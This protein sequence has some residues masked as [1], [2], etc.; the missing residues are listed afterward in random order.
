MI[1]V[2]KK[3]PE[4]ITYG[5]AEISQVWTDGEMVW[6][7]SVTFYKWANYWDS[8]AGWPKSRAEWVQHCV[9]AKW[10][11]KEMEYFA[12]T[13][14]VDGG[15]EALEREM[16][17]IDGQMRVWSLHCSCKDGYPG[18]G[19]WQWEGIGLGQ[20][21]SETFTLKAGKYQIWAVSVSETSEDGIYKSK[22]LGSGSYSW[23]RGLRLYRA[24]GT[25]IRTADYMGEAGTFTIEEDGTDVYFGRMFV[26]GQDYWGG[27]IPKD[28]ERT[29]TMGACITGIEYDTSTGH[30]RLRPDRIR[31]TLVLPDGLWP[32]KTGVG[33][34]MLI[35]DSGAK[36]DY[37]SGTWI[38]EVTRAAYGL[39]PESR[40]RF[41]NTNHS[42]YGNFHQSY[43]YDISFGTYEMYDSSNKRYLVNFKEDYLSVFVAGEQYKLKY[44]I[45]DGTA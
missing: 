24:D 5:G 41:L 31:G 25:Q 21:K 14:T 6:P 28:W 32:S 4:R 43:E 10:D 18:D 7:D 38:A 29:V 11:S 34:P 27:A 12:T 2:N 19:T 42:K 26:T 9:T 15:H 36:F 35:M 17:P 20:C 13:W 22:Y 33:Y 8:G 16:I 3:N 44:S 40:Q 30:E 39:R 37:M 23:G 45:R 1:R